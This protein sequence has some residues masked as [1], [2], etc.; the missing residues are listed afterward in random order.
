ME[1]FDARNQNKVKEKNVYLLHLDTP[2]ILIIAS[3]IIGL[4]L[5]AFLFGMNL[6]KKTKDEDLSKLKDPFLDSP[7]AEKSEDNY[8]DNKGIDPKELKQGNPATSAENDTLNPKDE[9]GILKYE[10]TAKAPNTA[11][12]DANDA[13]VINNE[14]V[15][16]I[17]PPVKE[18]VKTK[19]TKI[20]AEKKSKK[21][22]SMKDKTKASKKK[23]V[24]EVAS[25]STEDS[26][27]GEKRLYSI[28]V[29]SLDNKSKAISEIN[30]LKELKYDA[31]LNKINVKG[32]SYYRV[33]IGPISSRKKAINMLNEIQE[34]K[35]YEESFMIKE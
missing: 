25:R 35:Q 12:S 3:V 16:Q 27:R 31:H 34:K 32:K 20:L 26:V 9:K 19:N 4:I 15:K 33:R 2:R 11:S 24:V 7:I 18:V 5:V 30:R 29:A 23:K 17:I 14:N 21:S 28:Q 10:K 22:S 6:D 1:N 13:D 8:P